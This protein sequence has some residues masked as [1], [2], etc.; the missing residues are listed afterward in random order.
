M[1]PTQRK[2]TTAAT[3]KSMS[4]GTSSTH[5]YAGTKLQGRHSQRYLELHPCFQ[6]RV[7]QCGAGPVYIC[8]CPLLC[9]LLFEFFCSV[10]TLSLGTSWRHHSI[11]VLANHSF[12]KGME[13]L[14]CNFGRCANVRFRGL[15]CS[16]SCFFFVLRKRTASSDKIARQRRQKYPHYLYYSCRSVLLRVLIY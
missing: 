1:Q 11:K 13:L 4:S 7:I 2:D 14:F 16:V 10:V 3:E 6:S 9:R 15:R 8:P 12:S 5:G